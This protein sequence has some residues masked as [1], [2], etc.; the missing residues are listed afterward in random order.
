MTFREQLVQARVLPVVTAHD[1][2]STLDLVTALAAGGMTAVEITL[3]TE[4][5]L[6]SLQA[7][8]RA[9]PDLQIAAGT[10]TCAEDMDLALSAGADFCVSPGI[11][12]E[13]LEAA[14]TS[15]SKLL[16]GVASASD[17]LLGMSYGV[18]TFKLF[19]AVAV[20]GIA[21]LKS[22][23]GPFPDVRF[24]PTGGLTPDNFH[25][26]LA[27]PNVIC[28]GGSWMVESGLVQEKNWL[29]IESL[30]REAVAL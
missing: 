28:C 24:C 30:A 22:F 16:P 26:F 17:I 23:A 2:D 8:K 19:P 7:V 12:V 25:E 3:R 15:G 13:L 11:T 6:A 27:L 10:I 21:L 4:A 14:Q 9:F 18:D 29:Q 20:G 5:A 1:V